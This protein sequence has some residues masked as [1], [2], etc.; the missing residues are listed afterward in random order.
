MQTLIDNKYIPAL[1]A[2]N[3]N[4]N[5]AISEFILLKIHNKISEFKNEIDFYSNK[6]NS[7]FTDFEKYINNI[8]DSESMDEYNDYLS[9]KFSTESLGY[10]ENQ[11]KSIK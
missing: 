3:Y 11:L 10:Y 2:L 6:Y 4:I 7:S 9:W 5:D 8:Q 1:E